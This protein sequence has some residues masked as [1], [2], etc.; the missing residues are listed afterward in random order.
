[1]VRRMGVGAVILAR[2]FELQSGPKAYPDPSREGVAE[3]LR[4]H[5]CT[6]PD[7]AS[8]MKESGEVTNKRI[9]CNL[10]P[11]IWISISRLGVVP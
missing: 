6:I 10:T 11:E 8:R 7:S 4:N 1:M 5:Y 9:D 3:P 2:E